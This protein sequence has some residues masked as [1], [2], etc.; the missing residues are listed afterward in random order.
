MG[1]PPIKS[2][3]PTLHGAKQ[4]QTDQLF[5]EGRIGGGG[6]GLM[7]L[8]GER[9]KVQSGWA[10]LLRP[11]LAGGTRQALQGW[12]S[13]VGSMPPQGRQAEGRGYRL[14]LC[15]LSAWKLRNGQQWKSLSLKWIPAGA[16]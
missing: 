11:N 13:R 8:Y 5:N 16:M 14:C 12:H 10:G 7:G 15:P 3:L 4:L 2:Y 9:N 1:R 6:S